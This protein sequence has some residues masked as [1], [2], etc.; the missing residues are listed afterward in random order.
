MWKRLA[1]SSLDNITG[2]YRTV[3]NLNKASKFKYKV[4]WTYQIATIH[5]ASFSIPIRCATYEMC[6]ILVVHVAD[7]ETRFAGRA[8]TFTW[9][10]FLWHIF[11]QMCCVIFSNADF[12]PFV[13]LTLYNH[14]H[15]IL[16]YYVFW[17]QQQINV[18]HHACLLVFTSVCAH[19][20]SKSKL[21]HAYPLFILRMH[22]LF[23]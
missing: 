22:L 9:H 5:E 14:C 8:F 4:P 23:L 20:K 18:S 2:D 12:I 21:F 13:I 3:E 19:L 10:L 11:R 15:H 1:L 16:Q 6:A 7:M 17:F